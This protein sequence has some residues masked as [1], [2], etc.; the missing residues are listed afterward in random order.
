M[1]NPMGNKKYSPHIS[2][3]LLTF[4]LIF[5]VGGVLFPKTTYAKI[6]CFGI[7]GDGDEP[8]P[9]GLTDAQ[10]IRL[11]GG[12]GSSVNL[13]SAITDPAQKILKFGG[14]I[15]PAPRG[16]GGV[17]YLKNAPFSWGSEAPAIQGVPVKFQ[18]QTL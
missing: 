1:I 16:L 3:L 2:A 10:C 5:V 4:I 13:P 9:P 12:P 11:A 18:H 17:F 7:P 6:N 14:G 8:R 15:F